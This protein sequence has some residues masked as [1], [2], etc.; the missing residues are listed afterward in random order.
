MVWGSPGT[1]ILE[2]AIKYIFLTCTIY[3]KLVDNPTRN[4]AS[5]V[6]ACI[7]VRSFEMKILQAEF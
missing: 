2:V 5:Q 7:W 6:C 4:C 1:W 3:M